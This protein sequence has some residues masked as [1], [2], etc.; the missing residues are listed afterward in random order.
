MYVHVHAC[1]HL[2]FLPCHVSLAVLVLVQFSKSEWTHCA[3]L[4]QLGAADKITLQYM[5]IM[6]SYGPCTL[7]KHVFMYLYHGCNILIN[8]IA[9][10][11]VS[12]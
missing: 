1:E 5:F 3:A 6:H 9:P 7:Y 12:K 4:L 2:Y 8:Q 11:E 10:K